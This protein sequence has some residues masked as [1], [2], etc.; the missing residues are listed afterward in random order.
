MPMLPHDHVLRRAEPGDLDAL[1][2]LIARSA[3]GL[4][5]GDY[6]SAQIEGALGGA[7]GVD[8]QLVR[9]GTYFVVEHAGTLVG[10]GGWGRRRTLFGGDS[11][12]DRDAAELDPLHDAAKIRAFFIDPTYARRGIGSAILDRCEND[13]MNSGFSRFELMATLT[14]HKLYV[15]RGYVASDP[16][17]WPLGNGLTIAFVPMTKRAAQTA[18]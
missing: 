8:T 17:E 12:P 7:F 18:A 2:S 14:G 13:A 10:C 15:A 9:D 3:R 11:R 16:I 1:R 6:T 5:A 4:G